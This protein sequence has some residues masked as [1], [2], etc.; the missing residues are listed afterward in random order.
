MNK[1]ILPFITVAA[2]LATLFIAGCS[3]SSGTST[4]VADT[5]DRLSEEAVKTIALADANLSTDEVKM[6]SI[7]Y[8]TDDMV[9]EYEID[10]YSDNIEYEY[11]IHAKTGDI[12]SKD[13]HENGYNPKDVATNAADKSTNQDTS[14]THHTNANTSAS[15]NTTEIGLEEAKKIALAQVPGASAANIVKAKR[16]HDDGQIEYDIEI[17]YNN[18]EYEFEILG[19]NGTIIGFDSESIHH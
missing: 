1:K 7:R 13:I 12:L 9:P 16:D 17:I 3:K 4:S 11:T 6:I 5:P 8:E 15:N 19:S 18:M 10:F 14:N 2:T